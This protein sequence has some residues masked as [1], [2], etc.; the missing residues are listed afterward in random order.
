MW[1][2]HESTQYAAICA[3][4][5][6]YFI[7]FILFSVYVPFDVRRMNEAIAIQ[8]SI[9]DRGR[10]PSLDNNVAWSA[11]VRQLECPDKAFIASYNKLLGN[12]NGSR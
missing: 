2:Q 8:L 10:N 11:T 6:M 9:A 5:L 12:M 1:R 3:M 4:K 7:Y